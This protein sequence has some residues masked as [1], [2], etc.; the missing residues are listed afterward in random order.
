MLLL[1][2]SSLSLLD[3]DDDDDDPDVEPD[4]PEDEELIAGVKRVSRGKKEKEQNRPL[5]E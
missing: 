2:S 5:V 4:V 1:L 3:D